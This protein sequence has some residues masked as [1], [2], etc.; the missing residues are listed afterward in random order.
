MK[1]KPHNYQTYATN[2]I[3]D[4]PEAAVFL[5]MGLGKSVITLTAILELCLNR[6]EISKVLVI[7]PLRVARDTW[8][9]EIHKWDHL[10]GLTYSVVVGTAAERKSAL[11]KQA[12]I[13]LINR[14][15]V[16]WLIEERLGLLRNTQG[17]GCDQPKGSEAYFRSN[18]K[19]ISHIIVFACIYLYKTVLRGII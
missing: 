17:D 10:K 5:D 9:T 16:S 14:E 6:F 1:Y 4:H 19:R 11:Q 18:F 8:S 3:L 12:H 15:N 13:Y 7:A 2:F